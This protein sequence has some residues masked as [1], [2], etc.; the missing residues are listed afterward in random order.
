MVVWGVGVVFGLRWRGDGV[1]RVVD[2]PLVAVHL[3][4]HDDFTSTSH[5][6]V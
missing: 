1:D 6:H 5:G 4:V 3:T 2:F